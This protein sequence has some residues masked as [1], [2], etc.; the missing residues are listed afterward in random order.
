MLRDSE[1]W[2]ARDKEA[3]P[4]RDAYVKLED[5]DDDS[6]DA[7]KGGRNKG[8]PDGSK[9]EKARVKRTTEAI[10]LRDQTSEM[11]KMKRDHVSQEL[12]C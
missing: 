9:K 11:A 4:K 3:P 6:D 5:E 1:K 7:L 12:R 8:K 2:R 10:T